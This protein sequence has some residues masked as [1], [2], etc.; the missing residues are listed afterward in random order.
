MDEK[1]LNDILS[2]LQAPAPSKE[3]EARAISH[4]LEAFDRKVQ[5]RHKPA[6]SR[7]ATMFFYLIPD[8]IGVASLAVVFSAVFSFVFVAS[9]DGRALIALVHPVIPSYPTLFM[10]MFYIMSVCTLGI[11]TGYAS[12]RKNNE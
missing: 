6:W 11:W 7:L 1:Q 2:R 12:V 5:A 8:F 9:G 3:A 4:A 10:H